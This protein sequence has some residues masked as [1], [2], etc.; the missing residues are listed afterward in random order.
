MLFSI[1][2]YT[3]AT[4]IYF[5]QHTEPEDH[6]I[7]CCSSAEEDVR[8]RKS[9]YL[10]LLKIIRC[11][12]AGKGGESSTTPNICFKIIGRLQNCINM[13]HSMHFLLLGC[14]KALWRH[15]NQ[16]GRKPQTKRLYS[17]LVSWKLL[18]LL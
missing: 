17:S 1:F 2:S 3:D 13:M 8:M 10:E 5:H 11:K 9:V 12:L 18:Q 7:S 16:V 15:S 6:V 4:C 14:L